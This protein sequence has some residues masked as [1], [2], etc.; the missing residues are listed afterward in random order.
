MR[1]TKFLTPCQQIF[2]FLLPNNQKI[3]SISIVKNED[4]I[5]MEVIIKGKGD[6]HRNKLYFQP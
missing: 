4:K 1:R 3:T 5:Q 6:I 2:N